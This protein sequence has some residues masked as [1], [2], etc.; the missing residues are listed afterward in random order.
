MLHNS[1]QYL[2]VGVVASVCTLQHADT[3]MRRRLLD[4]GLTQGSLVTCLYQSPARD[5]RAYLIRG[6]VIALRA[7]EAEKILVEY[8]KDGRDSDGLNRRINRPKRRQG[9]GFKKTRRG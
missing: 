3:S 7:E 2:P 6:A 4:I 9:T 1:L 8:K 5:P